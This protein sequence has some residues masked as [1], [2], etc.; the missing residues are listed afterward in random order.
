[1]DNIVMFVEILEHA[2]NRLNAKKHKIFNEVN[3]TYSF[4]FLIKSNK[5][6]LIL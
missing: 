5:F 1:M 6:F 3:S 4:F 2:A